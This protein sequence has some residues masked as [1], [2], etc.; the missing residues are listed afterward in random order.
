MKVPAGKSISV[1]KK[2]YNPGDELP[3]ALE[4]LLK[5]KPEK[6]QRPPVKDKK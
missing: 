6:S 2:T 4:Y 5:D 1:E 3:K